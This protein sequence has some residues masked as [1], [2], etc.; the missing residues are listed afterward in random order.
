VKVVDEWS[1]SRRRSR[2]RLLWRWLPVVLHRRDCWG[3]NW[4]DDA[5]EMMTRMLRRGSM[6]VI[7]ML[8]TTGEDA[9]SSSSSLRPILLLM[10]I[11]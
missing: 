6:I 4:A 3:D 7:M 1:A 5:V 8:A 2:K 10:N 9:S 11:L